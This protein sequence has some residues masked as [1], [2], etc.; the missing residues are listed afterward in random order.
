MRAKKV[1]NQKR[2]KRRRNTDLFFRL[3]DDFEREWIV[4]EDDSLAGKN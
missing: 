3:E 2:L 4:D 1:E